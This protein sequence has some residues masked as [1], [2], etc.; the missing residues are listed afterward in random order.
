MDIVLK[1]EKEDTNKGTGLGGI[2]ASATCS[3]GACYLSSR[4][5]LTLL[6]AD[7]TD[8]PVAVY[9]N[10]LGARAHEAFRPPGYTYS[11]LSAV[12]VGEEG[13]RL[14]ELGRR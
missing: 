8:T 7:G 3:P 6:F 1:D 14:A 13:V 4:Q 12:P 11:S 10:L 9:T 2:R 5:S